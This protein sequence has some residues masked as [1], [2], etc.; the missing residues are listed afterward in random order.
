MKKYMLCVIVVALVCMAITNSHACT[1]FQFGHNGHWIVGVNYDWLIENGLVLINKRGVEKT[2][3]YDFSVFYAPARWTSKYGS[4]TFS[5]YGR[6]S[7]ERGMNEAGLVVSELMDFGPVQYSTPGSTPRVHYSEWLQYLLDNY[8][9]VKEVMA[10]SDTLVKISYTLN[11]QT[12]LYQPIIG[13][14]YFVCDKTG[15]CVVIEYPSGSAVFYTGKDLPVKV[16]TNN[17]YEEAL[18]DFYSNTIPNP[19]RAESVYRFITA[20]DMLEST[21]GTDYISFAFSILGAV[22]TNLPGDVTMWSTVFDINANRVYFKTNDNQNIR[23]IDFSKFDLSCKKP[24]EMLDIQ[25]NLTGDVTENFVTYTQ[26]ANLDLINI[27][28]PATFGSLFPES[29]LQFL[30]F[31]PEY[32]I[33]R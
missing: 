29:T 3:L 9:T 20:A 31:Y 28:Y 13:D 24:V 22:S 15:A 10:D 2:T 26:Q 21:P 16:L 5:Q 33:C 11:S 8:A 30:A 14:H 23:Y 6:E 7:V 1:A 27:S 32:D 12:G 18:T 25:A 19:D 17:P 4:V